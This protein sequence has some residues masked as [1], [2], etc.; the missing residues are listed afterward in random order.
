M[1]GVRRDTFQYLRHIEEFLNRTIENMRQRDDQTV[2]CPWRDCQNVRRFQ[3]IKKIRNH[4][5]RHGFK[6]R[7]TRWV[8]NGESNDEISI[9]VGTSIKF[10]ADLEDISH[11]ESSGENIVKLDDNQYLDEMIQDVLSEFVEILENFEILCNESNVPLFSGCMK[12]TKN[13]GYFQTV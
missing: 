5:I 1:Y 12:F 7:Y 11:D 10:V 13:N 6:E 8:W 2:L 4:L 3:N 9:N